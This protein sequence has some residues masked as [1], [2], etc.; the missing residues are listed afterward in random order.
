MD[1]ILANI[2]TLFKAQHIMDSIS[3]YLLSSNSISWLLSGNKRHIINIPK[4][5]LNLNKWCSLVPIG[6]SCRIT[7]KGLKWDMSK[8]IK[9][10]A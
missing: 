9:L 10:I 8:T 6:N 7:T 3:V 2:N 4:K 5:I 1:Q